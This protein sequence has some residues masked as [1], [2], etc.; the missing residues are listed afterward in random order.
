MAAKVLAVTASGCGS[1]GSFSVL[2]VLPALALVQP[3]KLCAMN[4][5]VPACA[6]ASSR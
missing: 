4:R 6:A 5:R 3:T 2:T 1:S